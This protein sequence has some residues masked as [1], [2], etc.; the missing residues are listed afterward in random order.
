MAEASS[1]LTFRDSVRHLLPTAAAIA[2]FAPFVSAEKLDVGGLVFAS[3]ILG[4][5]ITTPLTTFLGWLYRFT[6]TL[7]A[8]G[9]RRQ[10]INS[11]W[12]FDV[13]FYERL[14]QEER[15]YTYLTGSYVDFYRQLAFYLLIYAAV[16]LM[17]LVHAMIADANEN[18]LW[19]T[20]LGASTPFAGGFRLSTL[21]LFVVSVL[22]GVYCFWDFLNEY[23]ILFL[24][25]GTYVRFAEKSQKATGGLTTNVWGV[26]QHNGKGAPAVLV[27]LVDSTG[28]TV[29]AVHTDA[30]GLFQFKNRF[31]DISANGG[32]LRA[33]F[34][35]QVFEK[36]LT[37]GANI[38]PSAGIDLPDFDPGTRR[39]LGGPFWI[40]LLLWLAVCIQ[41][42]VIRD[43]LSMID[44]LA[45]LPIIIFLLV[46]AKGSKEA[47]EDWRLS[48][49]LLA[50]VILA[51]T[52]LFWFVQ[53]LVRVV[54]ANTTVPNEG[55]TTVAGEWYRHLPPLL[56]V[57]AFFVVSRLKVENH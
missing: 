38:V 9:A 22:L 48:A 12:N 33:H 13:L 2:L 32:K 17:I 47:F 18:G 28:N 16:N 53:N 10:W 4:Y 27:D 15:E 24:E 30:E 26:A 40:A 5:V 49:S 20:I 51:A 6:P 21:L 14:S 35:G 31:Q 25:E 1:P 50:G 7:K 57:S 8:A 43:A 56:L 19:Q 46:A 44:L 23:A 34:A 54:S 52:K 42:L 36:P 55:L 45:S 41:S 29:E 11:N 37:A 3:V 39:K